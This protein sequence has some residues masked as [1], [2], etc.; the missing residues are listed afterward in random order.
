WG[1]MALGRLLLA[2]LS[3]DLDPA[4]LVQLG[5]IGV[6]VGC[7]LMTRDQ[8]WVFQAGLIVFGLGMAPLFP[9][10]MSLTPIRLGSQAALHSIGFQVS[11]GTMGIAGIPTIAGLLADR[12]SL[13]AIPW[14]MTAGAVLVIALETILRT[15]TAHR[16]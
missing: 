1:A 9:T 13:V 16:T 12:T 6:L 11:A 2:P 14:T 8:Q 15:R 5:T 10:L 3:G 7:L 4:R